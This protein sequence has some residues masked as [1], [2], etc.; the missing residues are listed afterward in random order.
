MQG[1][2]QP[3]LPTGKKQRWW[4]SNP[5]GRLSNGIKIRHG[6]QLHH[7]A[8]HSIFRFC[9]SRLAISIKYSDRELNSDYTLQGHTAYKAVTLTI[10]LSEI[11]LPFGRFF[12]GNLRNDC[13]DTITRTGKKMMSNGLARLERADSLTE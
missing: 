4:D 10:E 1:G 12:C 5:Q 11:N 9:L 13:F 7:T 2:A 3:Y 6:Y 8:M